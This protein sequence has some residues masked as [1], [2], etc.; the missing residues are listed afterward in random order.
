MPILNYLIP[1]ITSLIGRA[2][3]TITLGSGQ[4]LPVIEETRRFQIKMYSPDGSP[5]NDNIAV[6]YATSAD[7]TAYLTDVAGKDF[8]L[9]GV[10]YNINRVV[11]FADGDTIQMAA[12]VCER[13]SLGV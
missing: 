3:Q 12:I 1:R 4:T 5:P 8:R 2:G 13:D 10:K 6:F 7:Y 11:E 9:L